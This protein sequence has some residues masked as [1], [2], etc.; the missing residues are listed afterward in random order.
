ML[1]ATGLIFDQALHAYTRN[2]RP[3]AAVTQVLRS[4]GLVDPGK[5][6]A[7][8]AD[9]G[10]AVHLACQYLDEGDLDEASVPEAL[11]GYLAAYRKFL[12]DSGW[13]WTGI[14]VRAAHKTL[15]YAGTIDRIGDGLVLDIKTGVKENWVAIQ[16]AAYAAML[17]SPMSLRRFALYISRD[18]NYSSVEFQRHD[19]P[20]DWAVFQSALNI[21]NWR[22]KHGNGSRGDSTD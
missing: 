1:N 5:Y 14:E 22:M 2:G 10:R 15:D 21:H 4:S 13:K 18:G 16:L 11:K 17:D 9:R 8:S 12:R 6:A 20:Q 3:L 7:G 19:F